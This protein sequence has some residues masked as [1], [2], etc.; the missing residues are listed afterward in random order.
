MSCNAPTQQS[1]SNPDP[2]P[3]QCQYTCDY[4][5]KYPSS[6]QLQLTTSHTEG[7][8]MINNLDP[9]KQPSVTFNSS[10]YNVSNF[11]ILKGP[12]HNYGGN[13]NAEVI[14]THNLVSGPDNSIKNLNVC[15]PVTFTTS[16]SNT[17]LDKLFND[18]G[19]AEAG[20]QSTDIITLKTQ[21]FKLDKLIP[22]YDYL[23]YTGNNLTTQEDANCPQQD[24]KYVVFNNLKTALSA[25]NINVAKTGFKNF[26]NSNTL[27]LLGNGKVPLY[28]SQFVPDSGPSEDIYI[29]C[30]PVQSSDTKTAFTPVVTG[31]PAYLSGL[32]LTDI[33]NSMFPY[34]LI[35]IGALIMYIMY[36]F[37]YYMFGPRCPGSGCGEQ[38]PPLKCDTATP[39]FTLPLKAH[40]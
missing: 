24:T 14:I 20:H 15:I 16:E 22:E 7:A 38:L 35:I 19:D 5:F 33:L 3:E 34:L 18:I 11:L 32:S 28:K 1:L 2:P 36:R 31:L 25:S 17:E 4:S 9:S 10:K 39:G 8:Y 21:N 30:K 12:L 26:K 13:V 6:S 40:K 29:D 23:V 27:F 37:G